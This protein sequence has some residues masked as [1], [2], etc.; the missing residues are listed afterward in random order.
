[1]HH[2][3]ITLF[4]LI[5]FFFLSACTGTPAGDN[6]D[7][8]TPGDSIPADKPDK[9][10]AFK[11]LEF[12]DTMVPELDYRGNI[13]GGLYWEDNRGMNYLLLTIEPNSMIG[14]DTL[15]TKFW[16]THYLK[17][18][19]KDEWE[20]LWAFIDFNKPVDAA[21]IVDEKYNTVTDLD[22]DGLGEATFMVRRE[23]EGDGPIKV[24]VISCVNR[25]MGASESLI[26]TGE[27]PGSLEGYELFT[28]APEF[29]GEL[30]SGQ[31]PDLEK[32]TRKIWDDQNAWWQKFLEDL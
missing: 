8:G 19:D 28:P 4:A 9:P 10:N 15:R 11:V 32:H 30:S 22:G 2:R 31:R 7:P 21:F 12:D 27:I 14:A 25:E 5:P 16:G 3:L 29:V 17:A 13:E 20:Q 23:I 24:G 26:L 18:T 1:M 6:N